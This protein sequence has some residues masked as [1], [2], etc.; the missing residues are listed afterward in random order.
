MLVLHN[1]ASPFTWGAP[2]EATTTVGV[3]DSHW[4]LHWTTFTPNIA[5][6]LQHCIDQGFLTLKETWD[7]DMKPIEKRFH[8]GYW[9]AANM[10]ATGR[11]LIGNIDKRPHML[12]KEEKKDDEMGEDEMDDEFEISDDDLQS[13]WHDGDTVS[14]ETARQVWEDMLQ[15][16]EGV[17]GDLLGSEHIEIGGT[18]RAYDE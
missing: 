13:G 10:R 6:L 17:D 18:E 1:A 5:D 4:Q 14:G 7:V 12:D 15:E 11:L 3:Y 9:L 8:R 2:A 16:I